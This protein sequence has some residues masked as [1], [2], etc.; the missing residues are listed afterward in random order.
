MVYDLKTYRASDVLYGRRFVDTIL[1][2]GGDRIVVD[3]T[4]IN[5]T[6]PD[7]GE[8]KGDAATHDLV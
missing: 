5:L 7:G 1:R 4:R 8:G 3:L 2:V 6:E